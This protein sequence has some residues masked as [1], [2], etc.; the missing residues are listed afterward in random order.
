M[1]FLVEVKFK[2]LY[3]NFIWNIEK[4]KCWWKM[5]NWNWNET[6][7][8]NSIEIHS[9]LIIQILF[10]SQLIRVIWQ[11]NRKFTPA[12]VNSLQVSTGWSS[13]KHLPKIPAISTIC[14]A[15]S[16]KKWPRKTWRRNCK[17]FRN[18]SIQ[19][20]LPK[21]KP[22]VVIKAHWYNLWIQRLKDWDQ[23]FEVQFQRFSL[24]LSY[25]IDLFLLLLPNSQFCV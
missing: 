7:R 5:K 11:A 6:Y 15:K 17:A 18:Q 21:S 23:M 19:I 4:L 22:H 9:I 16:R 1:S 3:L 12:Q 14:S 8:V 13:W 20:P 2:V 24:L 25:G 10:L